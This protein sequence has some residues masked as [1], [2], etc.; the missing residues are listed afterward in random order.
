MITEKSNIQMLT[1]NKQQMQKTN[2][3]KPL[4]LTSEQRN[5]IKRNR[6]KQKTC[7]QKSNLLVSKG[8]NPSFVS[9]A[10]SD[11]LQSRSYFP[12]NISKALISTNIILKMFAAAS[13]FLTCKSM[14]SLFTQTCQ[15][16][17]FFLVFLPLKKV[18]EE[19]DAYSKGG[20]LG[21]GAFL[22]L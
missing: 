21:G 19:V 14:R 7:L 11:E 16:K 20:G 15:Q 10:I 18:R 9:N 17:Q 12:V 22:T 8:K 6:K 3:E 13:S 5:E 2:L 4:C 1:S